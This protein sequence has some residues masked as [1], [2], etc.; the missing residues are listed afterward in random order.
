MLLNSFKHCYINLAGQFFIDSSVVPVVFG[1]HKQMVQA[2]E[3]KDDAAAARIMT[4]MLDH[5]AQQ[6][7]G[8][9]QSA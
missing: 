7:F 9:A 4:R 6:L 1:F 3:D 8:R 5:G 2:F